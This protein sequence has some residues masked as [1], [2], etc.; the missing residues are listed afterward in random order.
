MHKWL[1]RFAWVRFLVKG[2]LSSVS[3]TFECSRDGC[4][5]GRVE[6]QWAG[7]RLIMTH[8]RMHHPAGLGHKVD[9]CG[10]QMAAAEFPH[11]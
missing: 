5:G 8:H 4:W 11:P 7:M 1:Y 10:V 2:L 9:D 6:N 3:R